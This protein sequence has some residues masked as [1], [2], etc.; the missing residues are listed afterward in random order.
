MTYKQTNDIEL[1]GGTRIKNFFWRVRVYGHDPVNNIAFAEVEHWYTQDQLDNRDVHVR[2]YEK[3]VGPR[4][5]VQIE[6][7]L[8][9]RPQY[10]GSVTV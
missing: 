2:R 3:N 9:T 7:F 6:T 5:L 8:L 4:T 1:Q 10:S